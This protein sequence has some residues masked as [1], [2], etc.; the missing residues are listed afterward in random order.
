MLTL[1][2]VG[3]YVIVEISNSMGIILPR[4]GEKKKLFYKTLAAA[5]TILSGHCAGQLFLELLHKVGCWQETV[6]NRLQS[7]SQHSPE[8]VLLTIPF[9]STLK[10]Y[11]LI[12]ACLL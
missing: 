8:Y 9:F 2:H 6:S 3:L 10:P 12:I 7:Q 1:V 4:I 11:L 5:T